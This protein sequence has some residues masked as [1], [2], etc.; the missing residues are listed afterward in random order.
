MSKVNHIY[1]RLDWTD[2]WVVKIK[3]LPLNSK[4]A[5]YQWIK[6]LYSED[7]NTRVGNLRI[8]ENHQ[9]TLRE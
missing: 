9:R 2:C 4:R 6:G 7:F 1:Y 3:Y 8:I 5:G